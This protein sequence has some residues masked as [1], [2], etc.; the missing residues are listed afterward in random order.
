MAIP[1]ASAADFDDSAWR[2]VFEERPDG[3]R[4]EDGWRSQTNVFRGVFEVPQG[5][6]AAVATLLLRSLGDEQSIYLN[7]QPVARDV[8]SIPR[9]R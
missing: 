5:G 1:A 3:D 2:P 6:D 4:R 7:G 9:G 8:A